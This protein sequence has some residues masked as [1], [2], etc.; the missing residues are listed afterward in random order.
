MRSFQLTPLSKTRKGNSKVKVF[1]LIFIHHGTIWLPNAQGKYSQRQQSLQHLLTEL[2]LASFSTVNPTWRRSSLCPS[3]LLSVLSQKYRK[4]TLQVDQVLMS[5]LMSCCA[6]SGTPYLTEG[7]IVRNGTQFTWQRR[8]PLLRL[9]LGQKGGTNGISPFTTVKSKP[10]ADI[11]LFH[12]TIFGGSESFSC[13]V[14]YLLVYFSSGDVHYPNLRRRRQSKKS[15]WASKE[16][17]LAFPSVHLS[18]PTC[19][20]HLP[21]SPW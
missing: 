14:E 5:V 18:S 2:G 3:S 7:L 6:H 9:C 15:V 17:D 16:E 8:A 13:S 11:W 1:I 12:L 21:P 19:S 20:Q 4:R 10:W